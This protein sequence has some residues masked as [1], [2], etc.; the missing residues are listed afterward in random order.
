MNT[1]V[2]FSSATDLWSTPQDTFDELDREFNFTL[3]VC[4]TP[5]N[6]KCKAFYTKEEDGLKQSWQVAEGSIWMNPPYG[7]DIKHWVKKAY[8]S[9]LSLETLWYASYRLEQT[10]LGGMITV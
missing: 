2:M 5:E 6:A 3:D 7:R 10:W 9:S 8:D 1:D 4:A